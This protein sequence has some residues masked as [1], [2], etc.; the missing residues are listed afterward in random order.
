MD[1]LRRSLRANSRPRSD[2]QCN[3]ALKAQQHPQ[4]PAGLTGYRFG[5]LFI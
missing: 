1:L 5:L 4:V 3:L 2:L